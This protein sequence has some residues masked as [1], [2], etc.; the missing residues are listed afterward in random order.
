MLGP[1]ASTDLNIASAIE[2]S[3]KISQSTSLHVCNKVGGANLPAS[4]FIRAVN[5]IKNWGLM[6]LLT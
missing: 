6:H 5:V 2:H 4:K 3:Q 1:Y